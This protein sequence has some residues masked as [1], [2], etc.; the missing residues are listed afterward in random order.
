DLAFTEILQHGAELVSGSPL[1][2]NEYARRCIIKTKI[3]RPHIQIRA[4]A[5]RAVCV[6]AYRSTG[7]ACRRMDT[8]TARVPAYRPCVPLETSVDH[9]RGPVRRPADPRC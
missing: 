7:L 2:M 5:N 8:L 1:T 6:A 9:E 4:S 3:L